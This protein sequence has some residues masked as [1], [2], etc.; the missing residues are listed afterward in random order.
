MPTPPPIKTICLPDLAESALKTPYG[1]SIKTLVPGFNFSN[2]VDESP[3]ALTVIRSDVFV[4]DA[5][6]EYGWD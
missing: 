5:E 4:G 6:S 1:P 2:C 3:K